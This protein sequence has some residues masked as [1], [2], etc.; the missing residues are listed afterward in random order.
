MPTLA[1]RDRRSTRPVPTRADPCRIKVIVSKVSRDG[2]HRRL[3]V[4]VPIP[5][6]GGWRVA[7]VSHRV[8]AV[9]GRTYTDDGVGAPG[10]GMDM[11]FGLAYD[12]GSVLFGEG[13]S[14]KND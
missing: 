11:C 3:R 10:C 5:D 8:A 14:V 7:E 2:M 13:Y 1:T 12:L 6:N 4:F 9:L